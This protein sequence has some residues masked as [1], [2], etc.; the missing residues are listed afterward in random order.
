MFEEDCGL[1]TGLR[2]MD[3]MKNKK[4]AGKISIKSNEH[5]YYELDVLQFEIRYEL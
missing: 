3:V 4:K 1:L 2:F 5:K